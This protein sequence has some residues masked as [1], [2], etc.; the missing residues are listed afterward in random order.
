MVAGACEFGY[1]TLYGLIESQL[2]HLKDYLE[3]E[4]GVNAA[5]VWPIAFNREDDVSVR[6]MWFLAVEMQSGNN[7]RSIQ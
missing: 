6:R 4:C 3:R 2:R 1:A 7:I 5:Q